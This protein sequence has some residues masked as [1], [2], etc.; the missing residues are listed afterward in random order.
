MSFH[1]SGMFARAAFS[2]PFAN[3]AICEKYRSERLPIC[4]LLIDG[5]TFGMHRQ[6]TLNTFY[7]HHMMIN[8]RG[9]SHSRLSVLANMRSL[10][11]ICLD[12][13]GGSNPQ[14]A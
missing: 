2:N 4:S 6:I 1:A 10:I 14:M 11:A 3:C 7:H 5:A 12:F 13:R 8:K 9:I